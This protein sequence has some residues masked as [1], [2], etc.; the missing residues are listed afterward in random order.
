MEEIIKTLLAIDIWQIGKIFVLIGLGVYLFFAFL[1]IRQ[2]RLMT[3]IVEGILTHPLRVVSWLFFLFSIFVF[4][5]TL[6]VL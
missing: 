2:V 5:L 3:E 6:L 4:I 1:I